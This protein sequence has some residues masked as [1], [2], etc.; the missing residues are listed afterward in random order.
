MLFI[1]VSARGVTMRVMKCRPGLFLIMGRKLLGGD[2]S[3]R[4]E[5]QGSTVSF[6]SVVTVKAT[7]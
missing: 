2:A 5:N 6:C 1:F 4:V 3:Q 7:P